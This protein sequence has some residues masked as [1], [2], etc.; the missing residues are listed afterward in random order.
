LS[1]ERNILLGKAHGIDPTQVPTFGDVTGTEEITAVRQHN[2]VF[3]SILKLVPWDVFNEAIERHAA[4]DCAR[5]FTHRRHLGAM[6]DAQLAGSA[7]LRDI[8]SG[9]SS[10]ANRLYHVHAT[11]ARRAS[12][13]E[14]NRNRPVAVFADLLGVLIQRAHRTLRRSMDGLTYLIDSTSLPLNA[15]SRGWARFSAHMC[16]AKLHVVYDPTADC[17]VYTAFSAANVN[18]ITAA[19]AIPIVAKATY[20]FDLGYYDYAWWADLDAAGCRF[21]TR[22]KK[23]TPLMVTG[24]KPV[25]PGGRSCPT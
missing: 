22:L 21:V 14:A 5:S 24:A 13:A 9:L 23:N 6:L 15:L 17:P 11:P 1:P 4:Q 19:K 3:H 8:E 18:D 16:G 12:L 25:T 10:H 7:S 2:S 20:V